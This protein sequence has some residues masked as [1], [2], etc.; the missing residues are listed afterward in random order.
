MYDV[1]VCTL[2]SE[3]L[4]KLESAEATGS[5]SEEKGGAKG[6]ASE[7]KPTAGPN[8]SEGGDGRGDSAENSLTYTKEQVEVVQR[9]ACFTVTC[10]CTW[11]GV[12]VYDCA[13]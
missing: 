4:S 10:T 1:H 3:L 11:H 5:T 8:D 2:H 6:G 9:S 7:A 12:H 13:K